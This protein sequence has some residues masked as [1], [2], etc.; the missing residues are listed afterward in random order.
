MV[1][2]GGPTVRAVLGL[3]GDRS[4][5][6]RRDVFKKLKRGHL[7]PVNLLASIEPTGQLASSSPSTL[8][9]LPFLTGSFRRLSPWIASF[10]LPR[11][12]LPVGLAI[13]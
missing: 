12:R 3:D 2:K 5:D 9:F 13:E 6:T 10:E 1:V 7:K 11:A 4:G 8:H